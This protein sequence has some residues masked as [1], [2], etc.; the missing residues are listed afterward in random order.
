[1]RISCKEA[2]EGQKTFEYYVEKE[3]ASFEQESLSCRGRLL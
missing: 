2:I 1:M 3:S